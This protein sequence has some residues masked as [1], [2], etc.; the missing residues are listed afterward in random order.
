MAQAIGSRRHSGAI[1]PGGLRALT[2]LTIAGTGAVTLTGAARPMAMFHP[3]GTGN[4]FR[5]LAGALEAAGTTGLPAPQPHAPAAVAPV[6]S[7]LGTVAAHRPVIGGN[8]APT[9]VFLMLG[10]VL[11]G[12][13]RHD[14]TVL[15]TS[16]IVY[17]S[18][19]RRPS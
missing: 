7:W 13:R 15:I 16:L 4:R 8:P 3:I 11:A 10:A 14:T 6:G 18:G 19:H 9:A 2:A 1:P 5:Y 12:A 17:L